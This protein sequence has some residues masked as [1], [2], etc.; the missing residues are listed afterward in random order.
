MECRRKRRV[1]ILEDLDSPRKALVHMVEGCGTNL[2]IYDFPDQSSAFQCAMENQIDLFLVDIVLKPQEPNDFSG[3]RFA[4]S[5][6]QHAR[7]TSAEIVF[8]TSLAGLEA[9]MLQSVHCF[10][11]IEKPISKRRVQ[12][13]VRE[14]L[15]K[16]N[17]LPREDEMVFLRKDRVTY[18]VLT[19]QVVYVESHRKILYVYTE[20]EM[21]DVPNLSLRKFLEKI[22]TQN[23]LSPTRGIAINRR[24]IEYVDVIN[25]FVK[26]RGNEAMINIGGR[27]KDKFMNELL[28]YG[29]VEKR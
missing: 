25:R 26:M 4:M 13:V 22:Q 8:V 19:S 28:L 17:N 14:A 23:F 15:H 6:R 21:I 9:Q 3:I 1:L 5:I 7:Y 29:D 11:Y 20:H 10:D 12:K 27:S 2:L 18:P 24:H 16:I